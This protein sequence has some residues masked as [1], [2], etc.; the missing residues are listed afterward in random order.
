VNYIVTVEVFSIS[1]REVLAVFPPPLGRTLYCG[2]Q[3]VVDDGIAGGGYLT[4]GGI[5]V[6][7]LF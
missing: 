1:V 3:A 2:R 7:V 4:S 5:Y 6:S